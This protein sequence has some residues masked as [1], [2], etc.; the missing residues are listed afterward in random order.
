TQVVDGEQ[1]LRAEEGGVAGEGSP[2][3]G[4]HQ[5]GL[6]IVAMKN[7]GLEKRARDGQSRAGEYRETGVIVGII[8][9]ILAIESLTFEQRR[10][11][12]KKQGIFGGRLVDGRVVL[13]EPQVNR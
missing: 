1:D 4:G 7:L 12:H 9:A 5:A 8:D 3:E 13:R 6:P 2:Q 10:A 11:I